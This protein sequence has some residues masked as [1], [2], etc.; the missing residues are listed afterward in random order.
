MDL[1]IF[2]QCKIVFKNFFLVNWINIWLKHFW[3]FPLKYSKSSSEL[4][5]IRLFIVHSLP[6]PGRCPGM[7]LLVQ[8]M[9]MRLMLQILIFSSSILSTVKCQPPNFAQLIIRQPNVVKET[10]KKNL[11]LIPYIDVPASD[12]LQLE[13]VGFKPL[14]WIYPSLQVVGLFSLIDFITILK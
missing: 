14:Q 4:D 9:P 1:N 8:S 6:V 3:T 11:F 13:C 5:F 7:S 2:L 10:L 12:P